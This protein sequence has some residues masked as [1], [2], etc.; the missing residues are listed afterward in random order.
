MIPVGRA[1][2]INPTRAD[3]IVMAF[4][5]ASA[6][7]HPYPGSAGRSRLCKDRGLNSYECSILR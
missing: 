4:P 5:L 7:F 6:I 2:I 3:I 1:M